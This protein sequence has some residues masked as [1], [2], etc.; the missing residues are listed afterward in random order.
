LTRHEDGKA[1]VATAGIGDEPGPRLVHPPVR[2][3]ELDERILIQMLV[4]SQM[5]QMI[6]KII[7]IIGLRMDTIHL[8]VKLAQE[9]LGRHLTP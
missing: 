6:P 3:A 5:V 1:P 4:H 7:R 9:M 2:F 8:I